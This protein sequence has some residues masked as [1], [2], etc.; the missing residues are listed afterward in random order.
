MR[1]AEQGM[2]MTEHGNELCVEEEMR[3]AEHGMTDYS[4]SLNK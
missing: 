1:N 2:K 4:Y 3:M